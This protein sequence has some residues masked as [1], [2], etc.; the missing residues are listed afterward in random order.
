M[1]FNRSPQFDHAAKEYELAYVNWVQRSAIDTEIIK[2]MSFEP[3]MVTRMTMYLRT[4]D[5]VSSNIDACLRLHRYGWDRS[6]SRRSRKRIRCL[7]HC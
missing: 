2:Q 5:M 3:D 4:F 7:T 1:S 6:N